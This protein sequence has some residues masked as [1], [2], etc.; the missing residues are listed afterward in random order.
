M[1]NVVEE[2]KS[3]ARRWLELVSAHLDDICARGGLETVP[4]TLSGHASAG[5]LVNYAVSTRSPFPGRFPLHRQ[6]VVMHFT[7]RAAL[8][9]LVFVG[10][11]IAT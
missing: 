3:I 6:S 1:A 5:D 9:A 10:V 11:A 8:T 7:G 2:N 4:E